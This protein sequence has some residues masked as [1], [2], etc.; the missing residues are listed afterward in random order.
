MH[1]Q[2][3]ILE[4]RDIEK[5]FPGVKALDA[6]SFAI[7]RGTVHGL[8]GENGAGKST[9][10][11]IT[12][13]VYIP[14][15]GEMIFQGAPIACTHPLD[16]LRLGIRTVYQELNLVDKL[17]VH[18]NMFLGFENNRI[19][20]NS[21]EIK[22]TEKILSTYGL[23]S[24]DP[25]KQIRQLPIGKRQLLEIAKSA[26][27]NPD[28]LILD[29]PTSSLSNSEI[30]ILFDLINRLRNEGKT[31]IYISHK[32]KEVLEISDMITVLR[33][34]KH[35]ITSPKIDFT[36]EN[37]ITYMVNRKMGKQYPERVPHIGEVLLEVE[38]LTKAGKFKD[39]SFTLRQGEILGFSGLMGAGRTELMRAIFGSEPYDSGTIRLKGKHIQHCTPFEAKKLGMGFISEDRRF[40]GLIACRS[41]KENT[42]LVTLERYSTQFGSI[43]RKQEIEAVESQ[44]RALNI[45]YANMENKI[46]YLSGGNQQK[47]II[48][49]WLLME[50][51]ILI[52]DEPTR[53]I[54]VGAKKE[55]YDII[56]EL[57]M[58]H[59]GVIMISS[60]NDELLGLCDRIIVMHNG[61]IEKEFSR[62][63]ANPDNLLSAAFGRSTS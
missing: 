10:M 19:L 1:E 39:C 40:D 14:D 27:T 45:K 30:K 52:M 9:L 55:I 48:S 25:K 34:G 26:W 56:N 54:D 43:D 50:P 12:S 23:E 38:N 49:K 15:S 42:T 20:H 18:E 59:M 17:R 46:K 37:L 31:I 3:Y 21:E 63:E 57:S 24:I 44:K 6:V 4:Y 60:E 35:V 5:S 33:D 29:E 41:T 16:A 11:K 22:E 62:E 61:Q 36:E 51:D 7:E 47:V 8:V 28:L 2:K 32:L 58:K 13:G 53:G